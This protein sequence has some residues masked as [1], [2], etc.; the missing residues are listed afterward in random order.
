M[1]CGPWF[2]LASCRAY[3]DVEFLHRDEPIHVIA[4]LSGNEQPELHMSDQVDGLLEFKVEHRP[5]V[6]A[7]VVAHGP[8]RTHRLPLQSRRKTI[9]EESRVLRPCDRPFLL[10]PHVT[11]A[12]PL[13][14]LGS[15]LRPLP[16]L[17][18]LTQQKVIEERLLP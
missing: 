2:T 14:S 7:G 3:T 1:T 18:L 10:G 12:V 11:D 16:Q 15:H 9:E 6:A 13:P 8:R 5:P 4:L 17:G